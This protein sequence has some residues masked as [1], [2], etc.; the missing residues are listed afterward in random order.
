MVK[1]IWNIEISLSGAYNNHTYINSIAA[2]NSLKKNKICFPVKEKPLV[3]YLNE[4]Q[5]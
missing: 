2:K 3:I 5:F 4:N 1:I